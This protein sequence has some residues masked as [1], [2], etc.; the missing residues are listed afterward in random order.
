MLS[1]V[2]NFITQQSILVIIL[3]LILLF[4]IDRLTGWSTHR[5]RTI[6]IMVERLHT[7]VT[8]F[9][10]PS[11]GA[12]RRFLRSLGVEDLSDLTN[13]E[14]LSKLPKS[15]IENALYFLAL[16]LH[17]INVMIN[18]IGG[19]FFS[20]LRAEI[21]ASLH[22]RHITGG[23]YEALGADIYTKLEQCLKPREARVDFMARISSDRDLNGIWLAFS[24]WI[25]NQQP[26][27]VL[28]S[29][30]AYIEVVQ[31]ESNIPYAPWYRR[32]WQ[33]WY[34]VPII[35]SQR[36]IDLT[37]ERLRDSKLIPEP[38]VDAYRKKLRR[39]DV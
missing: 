39:Y 17:M 20:D 28:R 31:L 10:V 29:F 15:N 16:F 33:L 21:A 22:L 19:F 27:G 23:L 35:I 13:H 8:R 18:E 37:I 38:Q 6:E 14:K 12:A 7:Y 9:Y 32:E 5:H 30:A 26:E 2:I 4:L 1:G 24:E 36:S 34:H 3:V 25:K 11:L